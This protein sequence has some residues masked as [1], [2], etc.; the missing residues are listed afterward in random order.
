MK[1]QEIKMNVFPIEE[2]IYWIET[3]LSITKYTDGKIFYIKIIYNVLKDEGYLK[4]NLFNKI[5]RTM[6]KKQN[7][8]GNSIVISLLTEAIADF[9][10]KLHAA[11][12]TAEKIELI[13]GIYEL[14]EANGAIESD[15]E[16][17]F[18]F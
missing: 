16:S 10:V 11:E 14:L 4:N 12:T 13:K 15:E 1:E 8:L 18:K 7:S 3:A 17:I 9:E 2:K 5:K 6:T